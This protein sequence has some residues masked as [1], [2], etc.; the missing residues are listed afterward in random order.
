MTTWEP[1][2][3]GPTPPRKP[4][5]RDSGLIVAALMNAWALDDLDAVAAVMEGLE[6][7]E[8]RAALRL[9]ANLA[10]RTL[11][12]RPGGL[13]Q[14]QADWRRHDTAGGAS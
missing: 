2:P 3:Q 14:W 9:A 12:E 13:A 10:R 5:P 6:F 1:Y 7:D 4:T 8:L 11:E